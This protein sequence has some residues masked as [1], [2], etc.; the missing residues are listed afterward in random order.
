MAQSVSSSSF[1]NKIKSTTMFSPKNHTY[2]VTGA[3]RGR[4]FL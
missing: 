4:E 1:L 3:N 2:L